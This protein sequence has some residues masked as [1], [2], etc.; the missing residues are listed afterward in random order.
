VIGCIKG[1]EHL[2]LSF[3][4]IRHTSVLMRRALELRGHYTNSAG[5]APASAASRRPADHGEV[6]PPE[7]R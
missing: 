7:Q 2:N 6:G 5:F 1:T 4:L 3:L